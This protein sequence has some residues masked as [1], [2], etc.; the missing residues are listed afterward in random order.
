MNKTS[1]YINLPY[2][3]GEDGKPLCRWC[4]GAVPAGRFSWCG[5]ACV[6]DYKDRYDAVHQRRQ[7]EK[8]DKGVCASC[9]L[10][11]EAFRVELKRL[12]HAAVPEDRYIHATL[13]GKQSS[14]LEFLARHGMSIRDVK[15]NHR[16]LGG[17]WQAD[18]TIP[19]IEGGGGT[20]WN[21]LRTL[22]SACHRRETK[23]LAARRAQQRKDKKNES[24]GSP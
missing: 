13:M 2:P 10:D 11:T 6:D 16:G 7:V 18:H 3:K 5:P 22:C 19:V 17:F 23:A 14:C 20:H 24:Q 15:F 12:Y 9:Q 8:R 1:R 21:D 4:K